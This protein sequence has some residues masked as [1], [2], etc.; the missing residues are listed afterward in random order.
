[1]VSNED[2]YLFQKFFR[3]AIGT[4]NID[5]PAHFNYRN[6]ERGLRETLGL[7]ASPQGFDALEKAQVIFVLGA[8][9]RA[10][11]PPPALKIMKM[12]RV[13]GSTLVVGNPRST[14]LDKFANL[15]LRYRPGTELLLV[16]GIMKAVLERGLE[17]KERIERIPRFSLLKKSLE[18]K[19]LQEIADLTAVPLD[20]IYQLAT[21]L[22][23][24]AT[25][26]IVFGYDVF[27]HQQAKEVVSS[28]GS[29]GLMTAAISRKTGASF[30]LSPKIMSRECSTWA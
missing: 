12:A 16:A 18:E 28:L 25:G 22:A 5:S 3:A 4:N 21:I 17:N 11:C 9:V 13:H 30:R 1:M 6:L 10:E 7:P 24:Q 19:T 15:H 29:L 14:K 27:T 23:K 2:N 8:D 26:C 20:R